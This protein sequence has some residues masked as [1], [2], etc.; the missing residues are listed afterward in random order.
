L[1][2][3]Y[4]SE[5]ERQLMGPG[6]ILLIWE[7]IPEST[8]MFWLE[9]LTQEQYD[10]ICAAHGTYINSNENDAT[11]WLNEEFLFNKEGKLKLS[12]IF[13]STMED[14]KPMELD[15]PCTVVVSGFYM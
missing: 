9:G 4:V 8:K 10:K 7:E 6:P 13:Q 3:N 12:T 15:R 2:N 5:R 11:M 14:T 1:T